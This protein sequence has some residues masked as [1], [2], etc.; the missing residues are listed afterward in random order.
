LGKTPM[1]QDLVA[2][3]GPVADF[4]VPGAT[5]PGAREKFFGCHGAFRP[6][7]CNDIAWSFKGTDGRSLPGMVRRAGTTMDE[8]GRIFLGA[9]SAGGKVVRRLLFE[10]EDRARIKAVLLSDATY[11]SWRDAQKRIP[12]VQDQLVRFGAEVATGRSGQLFVATASPSPNFE[13]PTGVE[14]LRQLRA[15]IEERVGAR[16]SRLDHFFGIE[17]APEA[18]YR[19]GDVILAEYP[20]EPLGHKHTEIAP[21]VWQKILLPWLAQPEAGPETE[22]PP[23]PVPSEPPEAPIES[24]DTELLVFGLTALAGYVAFRWLI[25]GRWM[26]Q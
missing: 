21:Q 6:P 18:A 25:G 10:S 4:Q 5:V 16:F 19:L 24:L 15:E 3:F 22:Q 14:V 23:E 7:I 2:W 20:M 17:P 26:G 11:A 8:T 1:T 12:L 13:L 9:F